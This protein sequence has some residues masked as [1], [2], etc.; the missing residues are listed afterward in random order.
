[1][2]HPGY[3]TEKILHAFYAGT[4]PIYWG[5]ETVTSDFN[6]DAF[7][8]INDFENFDAA[9]EYILAVD[10]DPDLYNS[11]LEAPK[12]KNNIPPAHIMLDNFLNWFDAIVYNKILER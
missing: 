9:I 7:I 8:N 6:G 3:T 2:Q 1:M 12:F 11:Y 10:K 4:V 5:S